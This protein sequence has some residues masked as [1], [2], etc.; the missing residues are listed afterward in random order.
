ASRWDAPFDWNND[1]SAETIFAFPGTFGR[2]H[3]QYDGGMYFW[4]MPFNAAQGYMGF[5]DF[6]NANPR[7]AL[8]PGRTVDSLEYSFAL[9]KPFI[10]FQKY[11]DD[12]R[13]KKYR[14]LGN[15]QREGMFLYGYLTYNNNRDTVKSTRDYKLYI[16]DQVGW[17]RNTKPGQVLAECRFRLGNK[18]QAAQLLNTVRKRYYP[19]GS[20]SLY[21]TDGSTLTEQEL[22]DEWGREFIAEGRRRTDLIRFDKFN[23]GTWWD[24]QPDADDHTKIFPI[25]FNV[26]NVSPQL[27]QN[28]GY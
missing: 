26:L 12:V 11:A 23:S 28:P 19:T 20:P 22:L 16:R 24:K 13:L 9:G 6:G 4:M 15:S 27:K 17:F 18:A 10:K 8:Q 21:P 1:Q 14:N 25:G 3:W 5:T 2:S 7:Y